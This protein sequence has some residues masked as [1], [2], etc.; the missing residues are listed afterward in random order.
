M[1]TEFETMIQ[2]ISKTLIMKE[3]LLFFEVLSSKLK[4]GSPEWDSAKVRVQEALEEYDCFEAS[5]NR[6][7]VVRKAVFRALEEVFDLPLQTKQL[8]V[9]AKPSHGYIRVASG[10]HE[11]I[12]IDAGNIETGLTTTLWPQGNTSFSETLVSFTELA[13]TLEKRVRRMVLEISGVEKYA[14]ELIESTN[15]ILNA[16]KYEGSQTSVPFLGAHVDQTK[17]ALKFRP[18]FCIPPP[19]GFCFFTA[20]DKPE[21]SVRMC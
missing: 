2:D 8:Y 17:K 6:V 19:H 20:F 9:S 7:L 11:N 18:P 12:V 21:I 3:L 16:M 15:Y 1:A 10:Q 5:F 4:L 13:S 14:D